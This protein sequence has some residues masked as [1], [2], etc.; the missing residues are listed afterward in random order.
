VVH[1]NTLVD[2]ALA[3]RG[4]PYWNKDNTRFGPHRYDCSGIIVASW[5]HGQLW[6]PSWATW[7]GAQQRWCREQGTLIPLSQGRATYGALCIRGGEGGTGNA[8]HIAY[9]LGDGRTMEAM[10]TAYGCR[11]GKFD[12]R[13]HACGLVPGVVYRGGTPAAPPINWAAIA[14]WKAFQDAKK[15]QEWAAVKA[16][17][18][19][20]DVEH[21]MAVDL[22]VNP[23]NPNQL[24]QLTRWG[25]LHPV[26]CEIAPGEKPPYWK[27]QDVA[28]RVVVTEWT[29]KV[30][31]YILDLNG[32][33]HGFGNRQD[34]KGGYWKT[35]QIKPFNEV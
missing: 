13:F 9:S 33:I 32:G 15:A 4:K 19:A 6:Y 12:G 28:R 17:A 8:G 23:N 26:G 20:M 5:R 1:I 34:Q 30:S 25:S 16:L 18:E 2:F 24:V 35:G 21:G 27:G 10:G 22:A 14:A 7:S 31:G 11:I 29:P 3:Q